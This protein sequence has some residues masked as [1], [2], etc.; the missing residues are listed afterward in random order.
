MSDNDLHSDPMVRHL[1]A[2]AEA[3][4]QANH[5]TYTD[6]EVTDLYP[7][8]GALH[9]LFRRFDQLAPY[10]LRTVRDA[11]AIDFRHNTADGSEGDVALTLA[12]VE[13]DLDHVR[14]R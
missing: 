6:R 12:V 9:T 7:A 5:H 1:D 4:R 13:E 8:L 11:D 2:A 10:L 3:M 14:A